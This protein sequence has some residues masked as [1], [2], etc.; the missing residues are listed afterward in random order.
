MMFDVPVRH[1]FEYT[2]DGSNLFSPDIHK[3]T[4]QG[5]LNIYFDSKE[6]YQRLEQHLQGIIVHYDRFNNSCAPMSFF[7]NPQMNLLGY[8]VNGR[9]FEKEELD[10]IIKVM[11]ELKHEDIV[12]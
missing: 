4:R 3:I 6:N 1:D 5:K 10:N 2:D 8:H 11:K 12:L 9:M 7:S